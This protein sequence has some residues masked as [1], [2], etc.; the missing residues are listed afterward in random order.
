LNVLVKT[1]LWKIIYSSNSVAILLKCS[2]W[3]VLKISSTTHYLKKKMLLIQRPTCFSLILRYHLNMNFDWVFV[4]FYFSACTS[5]GSLGI[6]LAAEFKG[7]WHF[8]SFFCMHYN[9]ISQVECTETYDLHKWVYC[10]CYIPILTLFCYKF[11]PSIKT[12]LHTFI[13]I[14]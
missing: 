10:T 2:L 14:L 9:E 3:Q 5:G 13:S 7:S 8:N 1:Y 4:L 12:D 6:Y 11:D